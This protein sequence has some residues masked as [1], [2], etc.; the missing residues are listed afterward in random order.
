M[1]SKHFFFVILHILSVISIPFDHVCIYVKSLLWLT[2]LASVHTVVCVSVTRKNV[3]NSG[4]LEKYRIIKKD[5][6]HKSKMVQ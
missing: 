6:F 3:E 4:E 5:I 2:F 1:F